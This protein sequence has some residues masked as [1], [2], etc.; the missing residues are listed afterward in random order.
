[1]IAGIGID[2]IEVLR[3]RKLIEKN[4]RFI[5]RIFTPSEIRYCQQ[6]VNKYQHFAARFAAKE[7]F[8]KALGR[9]IK[10]KDVGLINLPSGKPELEINTKEEFPFNRAHVSIAHLSQYAIAMIILES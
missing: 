9:R 8:F 3:I 5:Q 4:P 10:W 1:M 7:A 6:K 2:L